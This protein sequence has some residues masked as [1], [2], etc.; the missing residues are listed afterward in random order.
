MHGRHLGWIGALVAVALAA[1]SPCAYAASPPTFAAASDLQAALP[2]IVAA[3]RGRTGLTVRVTFG[4]SGNF[5]QQILS[6]APYEGFLS[7]DESY[8]ERLQAAGVT[9][10]GG[11]LYGV[12]RI[13]VFAANGSPV[14]AD[15]GLADVAAALADGRLLKFAIPNPAHAPYGR[16]ARQALEASGLWPAVEGKLVFGEN[17]SQT[18]QFAMSGAVQA[19]IIPYSLALTRPVRTAG[20]FVLLPASLHAPLRQRA[21]LLKNASAT[22]KAFFAFLQ[23]PQARTIL[24]RYGFST[25]A[26]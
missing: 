16:A 26:R 15:A 2:E 3:F 21:V 8:V 10:D 13:G 6:G 5:A 22:S 11:A 1:L 18:T 24:A 17:A 14:K 7:A 12:G 9:L 25:A 19:A 23:G 4:S 20:T